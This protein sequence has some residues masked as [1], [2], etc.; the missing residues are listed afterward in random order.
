MRQAHARDA[1]FE[2][3]VIR[4]S[5]LLVRAGFL[6]TGDR[7]HA[8]DLTQT[9][10]L[11]V[12]RRWDSIGH[13]P[14]VYARE[15]LVNLARDRR[16]ALRRRPPEVE[17]GD[18]LNMKAADHAAEL[19]ERDSLI[20]AVRQLPRRE[21]E[22]V[23]LRFVLDLSVGQTAGLLGTSEGAVKGYTSRALTRLRS[24]LKADAAP[25]AGA[26]GVLPDAQ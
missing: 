22:V 17:L 18:S 16:R 10:L 24:L 21:R 19:L 20:R 26:G 25:R 11:R 23:V 4:A 13:S 7:G 12:Y 15:V 9:A 2:Q 3:F 14:D 6:L 5:P 8:E 1:A